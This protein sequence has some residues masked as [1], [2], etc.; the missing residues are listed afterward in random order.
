MLTLFH[1]LYY[2]SWNIIWEFSMKILYTSDQITERIA[3]MGKE[4]TAYY[5]GVPLTVVALTNGAIPFAADLVRNLDLPLWLDSLSV[6]SYHSD[7]RGD[8]LEFRSKLKLSPKGRKILLVD[9]VLDSGRTLRQV[10][11][12]FIE[13]G[14]LEVRTAV[15]V[16]KKILRSDGIKKADWSG[17]ETPDLYLIGYGMDSCELYRNLPFIAVK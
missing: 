5:T 9:E 3:Q 6:S 11:N 15:I 8:I 14:A 2:V 7:Q 1:V 13:R 12:Y 17:F 10:C 16:T 4:I